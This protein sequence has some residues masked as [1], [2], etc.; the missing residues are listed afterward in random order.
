MLLK[1]LKRVSLPES[2]TAELVEPSA[3]T[4]TAFISKLQ[5]FP[6]VEEDRIEAKYFSGLRALICLYDG[7]KPFLPQ[8]VNMLHEQTPDQWQF[9]VIE[10]ESIRQTLEALDASYLQKLIDYFLDTITASQ[11]EEINTLI[12]TQVWPDRDKVGN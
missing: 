10:G 12:R 5:E 9:T 2:S 11:L 1:P 7:G 8:L 3:G 6:K 4:A